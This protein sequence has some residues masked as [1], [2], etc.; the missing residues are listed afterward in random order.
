MK[1]VCEQVVHAIEKELKRRS[2]M[3]SPSSVRSKL[4]LFLRCDVEDAAF[5]SQSKVTLTTR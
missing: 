5:D 3:Y 1:H 2:A 4:F